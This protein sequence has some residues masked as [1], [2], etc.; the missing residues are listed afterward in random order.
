VRALVERAWE[1]T[2][3]M[4]RDR[5]MIDYE[6]YELLDT[7]RVLGAHAEDYISAATRTADSL[8]LKGRDRLRFLRRA[9]RS[10]RVYFC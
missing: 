2:T 5:A 9:S 6:D 3:R 10:Y 4:A 1:L 8:G 7:A